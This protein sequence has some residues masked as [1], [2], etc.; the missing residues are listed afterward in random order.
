MP[1]IPLPGGLSI[2]NQ[3]HLIT[4]IRHKSIS[5]Q[6]KSPIIE[7][8]ISY[9]LIESMNNKMRFSMICIHSCPHC[10]GLRH[11]NSR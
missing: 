3:I 11:S 5:D 8:Q 1:L 4:L 9:K 6:R 7:L 10:R 2:T